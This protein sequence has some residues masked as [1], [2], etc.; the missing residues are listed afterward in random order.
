MKPMRKPGQ[1]RFLRRA[2]RSGIRQTQAKKKRSNL[3]KQRAVSAPLKIASRKGIAP[4][5]VSPER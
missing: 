5:P 1:E 3:G 2:K 4:A